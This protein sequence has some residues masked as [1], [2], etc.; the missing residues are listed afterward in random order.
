MNRRDQGS[1]SA[2]VFNVSGGDGKTGLTAPS[3]EGEILPV[4]TVCTCD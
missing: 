1:D 4:P 2:T 3:V